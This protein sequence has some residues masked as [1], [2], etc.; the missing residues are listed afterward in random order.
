MFKKC[1]TDPITE[2]PDNRFT[3]GGVR[4]KPHSA[5]ALLLMAV[6]VLAISLTGASLAS[7]TDRDL[8]VSSTIDGTT[9][10]D[11]MTLSGQVTWKASSTGTPNRLEFLIDGT[12]KWTD[13][14]A[15]YQF[16][17]D[18]AGKLDTTS[19]SNG[20]HTL[21]VRAYRDGGN[22]HVREGDDPQRH[23]LVAA[24]T[25]TATAV[26]V[27][28]HLECRE[29]RHAQRLRDVERH[30]ERNDSQLGRLPDRRHREVD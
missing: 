10:D 18:P 2:S 19:L 29:R 22:G 11:Q 30:I 28:R 14:A 17:G 25:A 9:L 1:R 15:P 5:F 6:S 3:P 16:G 12:S 13:Q 23:E 24:A 7:R 4:V 20:Q 27:R 26:V 8:T 21:M